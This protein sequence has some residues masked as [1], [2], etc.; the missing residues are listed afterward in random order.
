MTDEELVRLAALSWPTHVSHEVEFDD[1]TAFVRALVPYDNGADL[2]MCVD[3]SAH[4]P[5]RPAVHAA[6]R[7]LAGEESAP[8]SELADALDVI[9]DLSD[10]LDRALLEGEQHRAARGRVTNAAQFALSSMERARDALMR[11]GM[12]DDA[13]N[14]ELAI[15]RLQEDAR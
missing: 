5:S 2:L 1:G 7:V 15:K 6:L 13:N 9:A 12:L 4:S 8:N 3:P 14:L 10:K 11:A